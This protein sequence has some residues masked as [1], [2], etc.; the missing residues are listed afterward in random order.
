MELRKGIWGLQG[1]SRL[2]KDWGRGF[3]SE[4]GS[5]RRGKDWTKEWVALQCQNSLNIKGMKSTIF[6]KAIHNVNIGLKCNNYCQFTSKFINYFKRNVIIFTGKG[7]V[8]WNGG[9]RRESEWDGLRKRHR[10][11]NIKVR[12]LRCEDAM[13]TESATS[14]IILRF[15]TI[16]I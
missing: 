7:F 14:Q 13:G 16:H 12:S 5:R 11:T 9:N 4:W 2:R 3:L 10:I 8:W 1:W 15:H 6:R